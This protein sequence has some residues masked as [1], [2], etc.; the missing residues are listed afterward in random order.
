M[1]DSARMPVP[2]L[3]MSDP[4]ASVSRQRDVVRTSFS[5]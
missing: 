2:P 1:G 5:R 4:N 3:P